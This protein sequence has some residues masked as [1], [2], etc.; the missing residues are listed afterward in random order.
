[1]AEH[2]ENNFLF[3]NL[4]IQLDNKQLRVNI[5]DTPLGLR[6]IEA[7]KDN[8]KQKRILEKNFCFLGWPDS[9]RNLTYLCEE[10]NK[11]IAQINSFNFNPPYKKIKSFSNEDFQYPD[12]L[13]VGFE[14]WVG[15]EIHG[16]FPGLKLKHEACNKLHRHFE[17]L[18]GTAWTLSPYYKI[19][20][21]KT[22]YAIRQ[23]NNLCHEIEGWVGAY[24]KSIVDPEWLRPSQITTFLNAPRYDLH[25]EDYELFKQ[26]RYNRELGGVYLHWSQI[27]KTLYE[28]FRD[29]DGRKL[30]EAT[31]S[32]INHQ[33]YYS[34]EFDIE[35]GQTINEDTFSW[36]KEEMNDFRSWLKLN[37]Y[38][39]EDP[40]LSLGYIKLGQV[41]MKLSFQNKPFL[42]VYNIMKNNLNI[43]SIHT[44][45]SR[46]W[47]N[48]YPYS[49]DSEDWKQIQMNSLK[50]GYESHSLR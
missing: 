24:R 13:P 41:D 7:L 28:V 39:W 6:W 15:R 10:L 38:D 4:V 26:N 25:E 33:K 44:I 22:K 48:E 16:N 14:R 18:Q 21:N 36:K 11:N 19:A 27:G 32:T 23:L 34:G 9:K 46:S 29:E 20:D 35:W 42:D 40:K 31:C 37:D 5:C 12:T 50:K 17:E 49:L 45:G 43:K 3:E 8:L 2:I 1:M 47:E 30:D